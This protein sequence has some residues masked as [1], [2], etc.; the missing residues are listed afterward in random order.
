MAKFTFWGLEPNTFLVLSASMELVAIPM[1]SPFSLN[2]G[3][4]QENSLINQWVILNDGRPWGDSF[5][6]S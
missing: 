3:P 6:L 2:T 1:S 4:P 5:T